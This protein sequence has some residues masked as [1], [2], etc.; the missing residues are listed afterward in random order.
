MSSFYIPVVTTGSSHGASTRAG[1]P[2]V[3]PSTIEFDLESQIEA[4]LSKRRLVAL[5]S[6]ADATYQ[7]R[8]PLFVELVQD[9]LQV[10]VTSDE[11]NLYSV[12]SSESVALREF[13]SAL[14]EDFAYLQENEE[15]LG[16]E[17]ATRLLV[18]R[19]LLQTRTR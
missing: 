8:V 16:T 7:L 12:G 15:A 4:A 19:D 9:G 5:S 11:L 17:L 6:L 10:V 3:R 2:V 18:Y 14:L 13:R 1:E